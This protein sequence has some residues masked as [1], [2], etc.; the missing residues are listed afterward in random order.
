MDPFH[1]RQIFARA[2]FLDIYAYAKTKGFLITLF[3]NGTMVTPRIA[4]FLA[5]WRPFAVEVTM[6][7]ATRVTYEAL[8]QIPG[9]YDRCMRGIGL[10]TNGS[11][12]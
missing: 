3:T 6:Y 5:E 8:T 1:G 2:D 12:R 9:S 10:L 11:C 4:D 7:G